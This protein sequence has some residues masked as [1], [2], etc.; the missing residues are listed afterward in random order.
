ME[1]RSK[2]ILQSLHFFL[3]FCAAADFGDSQTLASDR[4]TVVGKSSKSGDKVQLRALKS[5]L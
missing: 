1:I 2:R 4:Q 3:C 5:W